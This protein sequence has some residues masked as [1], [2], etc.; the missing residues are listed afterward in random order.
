MR[1]GITDH[2]SVPNIHQEVKREAR[3]CCT[4]SNDVHSLANAIFDMHVYR[5]TRLHKYVII[6]KG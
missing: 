1:R 2:A 4:L 5:V 6:D 3:S